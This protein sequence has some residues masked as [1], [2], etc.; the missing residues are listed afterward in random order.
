MARKLCAILIA[1]CVSCDAFAD[2]SKTSDSTAPETDELLFAHVVSLPNNQ[3]ISK[4]RRLIQHI[5]LKIFRHG[6]R[7]ILRPYPNDIYKGAQYWPE[8]FGQL[9]KV[10]FSECYCVKIVNFSKF[11]FHSRGNVVT[12]SSANICV[13]DTTICWVMAN[14]RQKKC[15]F[16]A[17]IMTGRL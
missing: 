15:M 7:T 16:A 8:G 1:L 3:I 10:S 12:L 4:I 5:F 9:T 6:D 2:V 17:L 14:I 13:S 11:P